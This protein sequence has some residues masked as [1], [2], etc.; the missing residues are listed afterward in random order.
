MY[1]SNESGRP[2]IYVRPF[3]GPGGRFRVSAEGGISPIWAH[4]GREIFYVSGDDSWVV[5]EVRTDPDFAVESRDRLGSARGF[6]TSLLIQR[7]DV[8]PDDQRLLTLRA[9]GG[10]SQ[11]QDVVVQNFFEELKR[12]VAN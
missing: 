10:I 2:E 12:L 8:A 7:F 6:A 4:N 5:A 3:P 1:Q 9:V 11:D